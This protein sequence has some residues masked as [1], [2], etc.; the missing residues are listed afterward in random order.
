MDGK[1]RVMVDPFKFSESGQTTCA[2]CGKVTDLGSSEALH[3]ADDTKRCKHCGFLFIRHKNRQMATTMEMLKTDPEGQDRRLGGRVNL[4]DDP[5]QTLNMKSKEIAKG[6]GVS[7]ATMQVKAKPIREGL[8][9]MP[10]HPNWTARK[11]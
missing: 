3:W 1:E 2:R 5:S 11:I 7:M 6:F 10:L 4:L 9:L 8:D